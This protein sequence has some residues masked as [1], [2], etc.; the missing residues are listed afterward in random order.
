MRRILNRVLIFILYSCFIVKQKAAEG[1][2]DATANAWILFWKPYR[3]TVH[4]WGLHYALPPLTIELLSE[5]TNVER[6]TSNKACVLSFTQWA[7]NNPFLRLQPLI[8]C[9]VNLRQIASIVLLSE[10]VILRSVIKDFYKEFFLPCHRRF[11]LFFE[12]IKNTSLK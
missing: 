3:V 11:I 12:T 2:W 5:S 10:F 1:R 9:V 6:S 8:L 4:C 7:S